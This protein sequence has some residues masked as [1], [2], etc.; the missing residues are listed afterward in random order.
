MS[1]PVTLTPRRPR[2]NAMLP[3]R[4]RTRARG[5][6]RERTRVGA[7]SSRSSSV[8]LGSH[9]GS[10]RAERLD[11]PKRRL[12]NA[13]AP[14]GTCKSVIRVSQALDARVG[15]EPCPLLIRRTDLLE[16]VRDV[17]ASAED[18]E[19]RQSRRLQARGH[20]RREVDRRILTAPRR[21]L[22]NCRE[23]LAGAA[24]DFYGALQQFAP[25]LRV[26][27]SA[28]VVVL[29]IGFSDPRLSS[30]P[31]IQQHKRFDT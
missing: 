17:V 6:W 31:G 19:R 30:H 26:E 15:E 29:Q 10:F 8:R 3:A 23:R 9:V 5:N 22:L 25:E 2:K 4:G 24:A 13:R 11:P 12:R 7:R 1:I 20:S 27:Y 21:R 28:E 18:E 14:V 16:L